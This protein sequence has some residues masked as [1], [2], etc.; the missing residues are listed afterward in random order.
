MNP[1][2]AVIFIGVLLL[3]G[4]DARAQ[5]IIASDGREYDCSQVCHSECP[6][7]NACVAEPTTL[8][9]IRT[10][11][12]NIGLTP[13]G[14]NDV[15]YANFLHFL[16]SYENQ[17]PRELYQDLEI[18]L[19]SGD[20]AAIVL[21]DDLLNASRDYAS[22]AN[23][24]Q[25][26]VRAMARE[27]YERRIGEIA[28]SR[29]NRNFSSQIRNAMTAIA[30]EN[31]AH[32]RRL[33]QLNAN[34]AAINI[35]RECVFRG[36]DSRCVEAP[37]SWFYNLETRRFTDFALT[38]DQLRQEGRGERARSMLVDTLAILDGARTG[39][40]D[41]PNTDGAAI[42][43]GEWEKA[44]LIYHGLSS[45]SGGGYNSYEYEVPNFGS[46]SGTY[47]EFSGFL[48]DLRD[49]RAAGYVPVPLPEPCN[50]IDDDCDSEID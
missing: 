19:Y 41:N 44:A 13:Q 39:R 31:T 26:N 20:A 8:P 29:S 7:A 37:L 18:P 28:S 32:N 45:L 3:L 6:N 46:L 12:S 34:L 11:L 33:Q 1:K 9:T 47:A 10:T 14:D 42:R 4:P 17:A 21:L 48:S 36:A 30:A 50:E 23:S 22:I 38:I 49:E 35:N 27:T 2:T 43:L 40:Y 5:I 15:G 16:W 24:N 25:A